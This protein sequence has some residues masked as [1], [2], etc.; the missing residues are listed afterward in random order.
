MIIPPQFTFG[1]MIN[2]P[3]QPVLNSIAMNM[4]TKIGP[5]FPS[6][7]DG[8][9]HN[10]RCQALI[11]GSAGVLGE[12]GGFGLAGVPVRGMGS[13]LMF[14]SRLGSEEPEKPRQFA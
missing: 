3:L 7:A 9:A 11:S 5:A 1:Q 12:M 6:A 10:Y 13:S 4:P 8:Y 14:L 2:N